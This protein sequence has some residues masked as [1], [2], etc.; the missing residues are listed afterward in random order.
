[1]LDC[2]SHLTRNSLTDVCECAD[3]SHE[4]VDVAGLGPGCYERCGTN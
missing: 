4:V 3:P 2:E 1:M